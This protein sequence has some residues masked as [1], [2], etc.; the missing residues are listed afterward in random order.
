MRDYYQII[1][2]RLIS[3]RE[4]PDLFDDRFSQ[5]MSLAMRHPDVRQ[6]V[7]P[8]RLDPREN[9]DDHEHITGL[10]DPRIQSRIEAA[11]EHMHTAYPGHPMTPISARCYG[12]LLAQA[13]ITF[14]FRE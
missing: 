5:P 4:R 7:V 11:T 8:V 13:E 10:D 9:A 1:N 2:G 12:N 3:E 14:E 6:V